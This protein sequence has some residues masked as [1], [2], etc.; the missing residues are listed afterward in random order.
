V[1]EYDG[2]DDS[3]WEQAEA[4]FHHAAALRPRSIGVPFRLK[5]ESFDRV[6]TEA[7]HSI[8]DDLRGLL[9]NTA[10]VVRRLPSIELVAEDHIPPDVLGLWIQSPAGAGGIMA[11]GDGGLDAI[12]LYQLNI[13]N[14]CFD[15]RAL[16]REIR[17]TV[18]HEVG[19][20]FGMDHHE[21]DRVGL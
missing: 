6:A 21:L 5:T 16:H 4:A 18:L 11:L 7:L 12:E 8:P 14:V 15:L 3:V 2:H 9:D 20:H 17:R 13:E 10:I 1:W 19:H